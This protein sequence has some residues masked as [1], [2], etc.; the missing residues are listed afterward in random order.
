MRLLTL[1]V[2]MPHANDM[3]VFLSL[4]M[5]LFDEGASDGS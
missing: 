1:H 2:M 5:A 3:P 4:L